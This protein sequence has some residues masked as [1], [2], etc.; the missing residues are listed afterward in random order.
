MKMAELLPG[1]KHENGIVAST[2]R[3]RR[4]PNQEITKLHLFVKWRKSIEVDL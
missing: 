1:S 2:G 3:F 4:P